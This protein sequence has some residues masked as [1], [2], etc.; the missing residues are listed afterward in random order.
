M[1]DEFKKNQKGRKPK[2]KSKW[3]TTS[4]KRGNDLKKSRKWKTTSKNE[5]MED[6]HKYN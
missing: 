1:E 5:K 4:I 2:K 6:N 3:K